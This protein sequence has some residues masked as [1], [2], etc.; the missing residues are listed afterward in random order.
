MKLHRLLRPGVVAGLLIPLAGCSESPADAPTTDQGQLSVGVSPLTFPGST[1]DAIVDAQYDI[2]VKY[3]TPSGWVVL[4]SVDDIKSSDFENPNGSLAYVAPCAVEDG[5]GLGTL[6]NQVCV[7]LTD[8]WVD[9]PAN[10]GN[11]VLITSVDPDFTY[12]A[13]QCQTFQCKENADV[14][15]NFLFNI[16]R[17]ANQGFVDISVQVEDYFCSAKYDCVEELLVNAD[18]DQV[19][20]F[21]TGLA[22]TPGPGAVDAGVVF[23]H[24]LV[25][26]TLNNST[27]SMT[28]PNS[29]PNGPNDCVDYLVDHEIYTGEESVE[30]KWYKNTA[31]ALD[32]A[33]LS[34]LGGPNN[35][36]VGCTYKATGWVQ[37][38]EDEWTIDY[39]ESTIALN[40]DVT[41]EFTPY[42]CANNVC[43]DG[44]NAGDPCQR[45]AR[46]CG[47]DYG[48]ILCKGGVSGDGA[49]ATQ[50]QGVGPVGASLLLAPPRRLNDQPADIN[51]LNRANGI[52]FKGLLGINNFKVRMPV[53]NNGCKAEA[54]ILKGF[55]EENEYLAK[56]IK[57]AD[58]DLARRN[59][60]LAKADLSLLAFQTAQ[61]DF[62][63]L[64]NTVANL[65]NASN[66]QQATDALIKGIVEQAKRVDIEMVGSANYSAIESNLK[67]YAEG[68]ARKFNDVVAG[69]AAAAAFT[70]GNAAHLVAR[71]DIVTKRDDAS[72]RLAGFETDAE[73]VLGN[74]E[75]AGEALTQC[76]TG[77]TQADCI[78]LRNFADTRELGL[79]QGQHAAL[80]DL[81]MAPICLRNPANN[82]NAD[83]DVQDVCVGLDTS[84]RIANFDML[85]Q[86]VDAIGETFLGV[87]S[88]YPNQK[89]G[90]MECRRDEG[91]WKDLD[92]AEYSSIEAPKNLAQSKSES[93][94]SKDEFRIDQC[95]I[96]PVSAM[97]CMSREGAEFF[98]GM[99]VVGDKLGFGL[100]EEIQA[101]V[102]ALP[103]VDG[104]IAQAGKIAIFRHIQQDAAKQVAIVD[105]NGSSPTL[106]LQEPLKA[107]VYSYRYY[108]GDFNDPAQYCDA[109]QRLSLGPTNG[110][111]TVLGK[112]RKCDVEPKQEHKG[113]SKVFMDGCDAG[114]IPS[115]KEIIAVLEDEAEGKIVGFAKLDDGAYAR[116]VKF[117]TYLEHDK[118]YEDGL[119][120]VEDDSEVQA[121]LFEHFQ[122]PLSKDKVYKIK[123]KLQD[124][125]L[126]GKYDE[127]LAQPALDELGE[128]I[129]AEIEFKDEINY[130]RELKD[131]KDSRSC[132]I[133]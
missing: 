79:Q 119:E 120:K 70:N 16:L 71:A 57:E 37:A 55:K 129:E 59:D 45:A 24:E 105:W 122:K 31:T 121:R 74:L 62:L 128:E 43:V 60:M 36:I 26:R 110:A 21:V 87:V 85:I 23:E 100:A 50:G 53:A 84:G 88:F 41:I 97:S 81:P 101:G 34:Q 9:D 29:N 112:R 108:A 13:P 86:G 2:V 52:V 28:V 94:R 115:E 103:I 46:D 114:D 75:A 95:L 82:L 10:P 90:K 20:T 104:T 106:N 33:V 102:T 89:T 92:N 99:T 72:A 35:P 64:R 14:P 130:L 7:S 132:I 19:P 126:G 6:Q 4:T 131:L 65:T 123:L 125:S 44:P 47:V 56:A 80:L 5:P 30:N 73:D 38:T 49:V 118:A 67:L 98:K 27:I 17:Q 77:I 124:K 22:C 111:F 83:I 63:T 51:G 91:H 76:E 54:G 40:W 93:S 78:T 117:Q 48:D 12:P 18:G 107:G 39:M 1:F 8:I 96:R 133:K 25:C 127:L 42:T 15:V 69:D 109:I 113:D 68:I 66:W 61:A 32:P 116:N 11:Q 3:W 58:G